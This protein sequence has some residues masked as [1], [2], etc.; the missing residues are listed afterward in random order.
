MKKKEVE[1]YGDSTGNISVIAEGGAGVFT[2]LWN[3]G[4]TKDTIQNL[5]IGAYSLTVTDYNI[6]TKSDGLSIGQ[7]SLISKINH[8]IDSV[9]CFGGVDGKI[10]VN[11][12]G[13]KSPYIYTWNLSPIVV[14]SVLTNL[15]S[16][17][18]YLEIKDSLNCKV[19]DTIYVPQPSPVSLTCSQ[20]NVSCFGGNNGTILIKARGG[21]NIF[22]YNLGSGYQSDSNFSNLIIG[23][24]YGKIMDQKGCLDSISINLTQPNEMKFNLEKMNSACVESKNGKAAIT[25]ISGGTSPYSYLWSNGQIKDTC[26]NITGKTWISGT[27]IDSNQCKKRDSIFVNT[28]YALNIKLT[29]DSLTCFSGSNGKAIAKPLNGYL[30][31]TYQWNSSPVQSTDSAKNLSQ[32][33][34]TVTVFDKFNCQKIDS[35]SVKEPSQISI[36]FTKKNPSCYLKVDGTIS[37]K[38]TGGFSPYTYL[39][40]TTPPQTDSISIKLTDDTYTLEVTDRKGCKVNKSAFLTQPS[41]DVTIQLLEKQNS[42]CFGFNNGKLKILATGGTPPYQYIW[43]IIP[44]KDSAFIQNLAANKTY[45]L[46]VADINN[47]KD[48]SSYYITEPTPIDFKLKTKKDITC[49]GYNNGLIALDCKGGKKPYSFSFDSFKTRS[50]SV[51][52]EYLLPGIYSIAVKDS[53]Q[54]TSKFDVDI[55]EPEELVVKISPQIDTIDMCSSIQ[56]K[57]ILSTKSNIIPADVIYSW[58]P[59]QGLSCSDC[60]DP[61]TNTYGT[62][63]YPLTV[64]YNNG[65]CKVNKEAMIYVRVAEPIFIPNAFSPNGDN[66]ND[67]FSVYGNCIKAKNMMIFDRWGEKIYHEYGI[68]KAWDGRFKN[69]PMPIGVYSYIVYVTFMNNE[70][71][72]FTGELLLTK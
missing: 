41:K 70:I 56:L 25:N 64:T 35:I 57:T 11:Y 69:V 3:T 28:D 46:T 68:E 24:Y 65:L 17:S 38:V 44:V 8:K 72:K 32:G 37:A 1:C 55:I 31:Y 49:Y 50:N 16:K 21:N 53:N 13:G 7:N 39:W 22:Q 40:N 12:Q 2:Y 61:I 47:C 60:R 18:Y 52:Y 45:K 10:K 14:D 71:K 26:I 51:F 48:T 43:N 9:S 34:Y 59:N 42:T 67:S 33:M 66:L 29:A 36:L 15:N 63:K 23:S 62:L 5:K 27:V 58:L 4:S 19:Y 6:C 20:K 30:P 54:C